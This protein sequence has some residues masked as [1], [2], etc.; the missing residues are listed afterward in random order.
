MDLCIGCHASLPVNAEACEQCGIPLESRSSQLRCGQCQQQPPAFDSCLALYRYHSP[1]D[2]LITRLKFHH[3]LACARLLAGLMRE[4]IQKLK[5][6]PEAILPVPLHPSRLKERGFN[7]ALEIARPL[8]R[9][10]HIPLLL[11]QCERTRATAMQ[12]SLPAKQRSKNVKGVF[13]I[14]QAIPHKHVAI[15]DDVMTT[16]Q[17]VQELAKVLRAAGVQQ[18]DVW[19]VARAQLK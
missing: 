15:V 6:F 14:R 17:T 16:G 9:E 7:Q 11:H 13:R 4:K 5:Q 18:I 1:V 2:E 19:V 3:R 8:A 12:S 10:F